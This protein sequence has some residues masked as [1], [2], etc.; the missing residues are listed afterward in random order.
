MTEQ[1]PELA[2]YPWLPTDRVHRWLKLTDT[3]DADLLAL[4]EDCRQAAGDYCERQRPDLYAPATETTP[5]RFAAT[6]SVVQAGVLS[7]ARLYARIGSPAGLAAYAEIGAAEIL[8]IDP[9]V[10]RLL[11]VGRY[12]PPRVG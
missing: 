4:V 3:D 5:A 7:A 12:A 6:P 1:P 11:G 8:R 10:T 9:D 2:P